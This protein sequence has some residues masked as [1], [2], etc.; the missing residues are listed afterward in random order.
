MTSGLLSIC[1]VDRSAFQ[2]PAMDPVAAAAL[3]DAVLSV[4][5]ALPVVEPCLLHAPSA[6][7][8]TA[9]SAVMIVLVIENPLVDWSRS[10]GFVTQRLGRDDVVRAELNHDGL[11][12]AI[13]GVNAR[14]TGATR[15][16]LKSLP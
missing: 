14:L 3:P 7:M 4:A 1:T 8:E 6:M 10:G 12:T 13:D 2:V 5:A 16:I 15:S 11:E 9:A